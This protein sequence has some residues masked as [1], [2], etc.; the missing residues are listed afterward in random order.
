VLWDSEAPG[1]G[2]RA[3]RVELFPSHRA[4]RSEAGPRGESQ[5]AF[6]SVVLSRHGGFGH[7]AYRYNGLA[8]SALWNASGL[9][10]ASCPELC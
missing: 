6:I 10:G 9:N 3:G 7:G 4:L 1:R 5:P 2:E 8:F